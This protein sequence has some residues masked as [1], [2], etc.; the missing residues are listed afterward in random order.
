M[1]SE[2]NTNFT[3]WDELI[4]REEVAQNVNIL[5]W[6]CEIENKLG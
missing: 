3:N 4:R 1:C 2:L 5:K 6:E